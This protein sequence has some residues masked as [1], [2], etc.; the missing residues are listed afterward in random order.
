MDT[1]WNEI[2]K[3]RRFDR[4]GCPSEEDE[5]LLREVAL[6]TPRCI[7]RQKEQSQ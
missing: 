4:D 1:G 7:E 6:A 5:E 3:N 2:L